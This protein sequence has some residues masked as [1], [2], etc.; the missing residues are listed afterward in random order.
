MLYPYD[1]IQDAYNS[2]VITGNHALSERYAAC[3]LWLL[4]A[5]KEERAE[6]RDEISPR[7]HIN[8]PTENRRHAS[9]TATPGMVGID[10]GL[11]LV[12]GSV[13]AR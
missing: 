10:G 3:W 6:R 8:L 7:T 12:G 5:E 13:L 9:S 11:T 1:S 2:A 4:I